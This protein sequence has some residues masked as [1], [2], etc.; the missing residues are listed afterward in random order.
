[1]VFHLSIIYLYVHLLI[2]LYHLLL[3]LLC[4]SFYFV[5]VLLLLVLIMVVMCM[6]IQRVRL[7]EY[8]ILCTMAS[9]LFLFVDASIMSSYYHQSSR[10]SIVYHQSSA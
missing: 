6:L 7:G 9:L 2:L 1:M 10:G 3:F 5:N 8:S 4:Q